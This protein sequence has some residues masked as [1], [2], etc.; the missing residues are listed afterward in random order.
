VY[1]KWPDVPMTALRSGARFAPTTQVRRQ[2]TACYYTA[3]LFSG[4]DCQSPMYF[5]PGPR[6]NA[7]EKSVLY[8]K[9]PSGQEK[10]PRWIEG[11]V[12]RLA[13]SAFR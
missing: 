9:R 11:F 4:L 3:P 13:T 6:W 5:S 7:I 1:R 12:S 2:V 10:S 8:L